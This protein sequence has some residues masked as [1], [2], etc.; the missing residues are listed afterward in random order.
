MNQYYM[1]YKIG[2]YMLKGQQT[3]F[4]ITKAKSDDKN[5]QE[6]EVITSC[7]E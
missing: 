4:S 2:I 1:I 5:E 7:T 3:G 6:N